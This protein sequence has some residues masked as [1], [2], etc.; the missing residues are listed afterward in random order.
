[1][2]RLRISQSKQCFSRLNPVCSTYKH[3]I[4]VINSVRMLR[5]V[6]IIHKTYFTQPTRFMRKEQS[7]GGIFA[8]IPVNS[9]ATIAEESNKL[10][11]DGKLLVY[12]SVFV[13]DLKIN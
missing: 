13:H 3:V 11:A 1:M 2:F 7:M 8:S 9:Q 10:D 12:W 5:R 4:P 6:S